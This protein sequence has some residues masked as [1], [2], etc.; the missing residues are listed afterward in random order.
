MDVAFGSALQSLSQRL[1]SLSISR[2]TLPSGQDQDDDVEVVPSVRGDEDDDSGVRFEFS[3]LRYRREADAVASQQRTAG[4]VSEQLGFTTG[5]IEL[6]EDE[7]LFED[8]HAAL[9]SLQ[10]ALAQLTELINEVEEAIGPHLLGDAPEDTTPEGGL[11]A[12]D[13]PTVEIDLTA[14]EPAAA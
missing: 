7:D 13:D 3:S 6:T 1:E 14:L 2:P 10:E 11:P 12:S 4:V 5:S 8:L 9:E